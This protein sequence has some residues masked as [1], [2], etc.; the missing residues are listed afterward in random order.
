MGLGITPLA[1][2]VM[3]G[4]A[5]DDAGAVA[6]ALATM[7]NVGNAVGVAVIGVVFFGSV[8]AGFAHAFELSLGVLAVTL[9][10]VAG[11]TRLLPATVRS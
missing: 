8:H 4:M 1:T 2:I 6:G 11:L 5:P 7:Q 3:S 9:V 10:S